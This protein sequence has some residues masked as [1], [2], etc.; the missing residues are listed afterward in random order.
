MPGLVQP[1]GSQV[2]GTW[3]FGLLLL[4]AQQLGP[5][6]DLLQ[7]SPTLKPLPFGSRI[8]MSSLCASSKRFCLA[9]LFLV[10][11]CPVRAAN[12]RLPLKGSA[13][14]APSDTMSLQQSSVN[15]ALLQ[16]CHAGQSL[17]DATFIRLNQ[18][19]NTN[20]AAEQQC[21]EMLEAQCSD[22]P[23]TVVKQ[24]MLMT[25]QARASDWSSMDA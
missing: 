21:S 7:P 15:P 19:C 3:R 4:E 14:G 12:K 8:G 2:G 6:P 23:Q 11:L 17:Q 9:R 22:W 18:T 25:E 1:E 24:L 16:N 20:T 10:M 13:R 5:L